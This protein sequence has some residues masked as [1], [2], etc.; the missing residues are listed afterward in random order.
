[1]YDIH[2]FSAKDD[3]HEDSMDFWMSEAR[4]RSAYAETLRAL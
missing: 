2:E 4:A 1:M 3:S